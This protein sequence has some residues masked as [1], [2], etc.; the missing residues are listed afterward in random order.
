ML[1]PWSCRSLLLACFSISCSFSYLNMKSCATAASMAFLVFGLFC[2]S[3]ASLPVTVT[4]IVHII[5]APFV[6]F[7]MTA[8]ILLPR[9]FG[10]FGVSLV[11][12]CARRTKNCSFSPFGPLGSVPRAAAFVVTGAQRG[13]LDS[14]APVKKKGSVLRLSFLCRRSGLPPL[15]VCRRI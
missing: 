6:C 13:A 2:T 7:Y 1:P 10:V 9:V 3:S 4:C 14:V 8:A 15:E 11:F 12:F 5:A